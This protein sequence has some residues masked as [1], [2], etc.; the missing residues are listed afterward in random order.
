MP[1]I[2]GEKVTKF[3]GGLA[4]VAGVDFHVDEGEIV[5]LIGPNGAGKTTLFNLVSGALPLTSGKMRFKGK[6]ITHL[7]PHQIC[8]LGIGRTFQAGFHLFCRIR[9]MFY[10][11]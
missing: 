2:E 7:R 4:A 5:G 11:D 3:F 8:K 9:G 1:I 6:D 10:L